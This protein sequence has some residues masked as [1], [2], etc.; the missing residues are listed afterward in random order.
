[1]NENDGCKFFFLWGC[2]YYIDSGINQDMMTKAAS[3][4]FM[5][6]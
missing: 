1:M 4:E 6:L 5:T 2:K 3:W